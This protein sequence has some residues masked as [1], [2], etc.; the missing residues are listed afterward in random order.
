MPEIEPR[1]TMRHSLERYQLREKLAGNI[2]Y[3][4]FNRYLETFVRNTG[5][6]LVEND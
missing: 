3:C 4:Y 1:I 6:K 2:E 5:R